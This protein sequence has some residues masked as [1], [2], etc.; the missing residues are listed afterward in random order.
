[1]SPS[2]DDIRRIQEAGFADILQIHKELRK[3]SVKEATLP[4][5]YALNLPAARKPSDALTQILQPIEAL[6]DELHER[7]TGL[8]ADAPQFGSGKTFDWKGSAE[9]FKAV[10]ESPP[11]GIKR[12][13]ILAG[14]LNSENVPE[15][16]STFRPDIVDV[17]SGVE[18]NFGK[19]RNMIAAFVKAARGET[20]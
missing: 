8:L 6:P 9:M 12:L 15:G 20:R 14:G 1:V 3:E 2:A 5:W 18:G 13:L 4:V 17:S 10:A 7:I 16:I 19:D 11:D